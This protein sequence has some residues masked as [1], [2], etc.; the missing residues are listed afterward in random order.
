MNRM[1]NK[2]RIAHAA[3]EAQAKEK[4]KASAKEAKKEAKPKAR[5]K[6][7]VVAARMKVVWE[8]CGGSG[9][10]LKA[11]PYSEKAGADADAAARTNST[12]KQHSVRASKVPM[13]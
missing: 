4:E 12:G 13:E 11:F 3:A 5:T 6:K 8:V 7:V 1:S 9:V 2:D 10:A